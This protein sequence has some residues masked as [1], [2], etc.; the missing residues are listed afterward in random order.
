MRVSRWLSMALLCALLLLLLCVSVRAHEPPAHNTAASQLKLTHDIFEGSNKDPFVAL[1]AAELKRGTQRTGDSA[2]ERLQWPKQLTLILAHPDA[3]WSTSIGRG[4][5]R[6]QSAL[7]RGFSDTIFVNVILVGLEGSRGFL[8]P[9]ARPASLLTAQR[10]AGDIAEQVRISKA[11]LQALVAHEPLLVQRFHTFDGKPLHVNGSV[12]FHV[13]AAAKGG[14][15]VRIRDAVGALLQSHTTFQH[16]PIETMDDII[17][18]DYEKSRTAVPTIYIVNSGRRHVGY[19]WRSVTRGCSTPH[20][21]GQHHNYFW[22]DLNAGPLEWGPVTSGEGIVSTHAI[23]FIEDETAFADARTRSAFVAAV[24]GYVVHTAQR[25]LSTSITRFP[26]VGMRADAAI[27]LVLIADTRAGLAA[28]EQQ[29][30][31]VQKSLEEGT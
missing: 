30:A 10:W 17:R 14:L 23:P 27:Q 26:F 22:L 3:D 13:T 29:M 2:Q 5:L 21:A 4:R 16:L 20:F 24:A 9:F 28:L 1:T 11:D 19:A 7:A 25:L 31:T 12:H 18:A 15:A 8:V 6:F